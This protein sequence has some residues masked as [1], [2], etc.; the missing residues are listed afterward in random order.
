MPFNDL[1]AH[2]RRVNT[3]RPNWPPKTGPVGL[4]RKGASALLPAEWQTPRWRPNLL[5]LSGYRAALAPR[6]RHWMELLGTQSLVDALAGGALLVPMLVMFGWHPAVITGLLVVPMAAGVFQPLLPIALDRTGGNLS[7]IA[8]LL[9]GIAAFRGFALLATAVASLLEAPGWITLPLALVSV[10]LIGVGILARRILLSWVF[11]A[12][13]DAQRRV[14][15]PPMSAIAAIV[16]AAALLSV[17]GLLLLSPDDADM[18]VLA[19]IFAVAGGV[20][21]RELQLTRALPSPGRVRVPNMRQLRAET[22]PDLWRFIKGVLV[23]GLGGGMTPIFALYAVDGLGMPPFAAALIGSLTLLAGVAGAAWGGAKL[24][25]GSSASL[26]KLSLIGRGLAAG[27]MVL[28]FPGAAWAY[29]L[30]L[31]CAV[32]MT[33]SW[34]IGNLALSERLFRMV[35]GP[36][37][38]GQFGRV[39]AGNDLA[40]LVGQL[41]SAGALAVA[42]I[43][44]V[45]AVLFAGS[46]ALRFVALLLERKR[47]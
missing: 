2:L 31:G 21:L 5:D 7:G 47:P 11:I 17:T 37:G 36:N 22:P 13:P 25:R 29:P 6:N 27:A 28:A 24:G 44:A 10:L 30:L 26:W 45:Y 20:A 38:M 23:T 16:A 32:L 33:F 42:P 4:L 14:V 40:L 9:T 46:G 35:N 39:N 34:A 19:A 1:A 43:Y 15:L 41:A 12:M 18:I 3:N 8:Q